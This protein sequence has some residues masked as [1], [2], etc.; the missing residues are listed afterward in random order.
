MV[1]WFNVDEARKY[2]LE[3]GF[4]Y[5]LRPKKR[6]EGIEVLSY[7]G[8]GKKGM[9]TVKLIKEIKDIKELSGYVD[10][11]GFKT[12]EEWLKEADKSRFLYEVRVLWAKYRLEEKNGITNT[13]K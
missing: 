2:L 10:Q 13:I 1:I 3:T 7:D 9:V 12:V 6:R 5:T 8:F 11:S 4:V